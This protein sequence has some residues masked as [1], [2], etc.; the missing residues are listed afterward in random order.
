VKIHGDTSSG[1]CLK[2]KYTADHLGLP[3]TWIA[4]SA[5]DG[6]TKRPEFLARNP[7]GQIPVIE[8]DDGRHL[9]QSNAIIRY[10]ARGT[11]LLPDDPFTQ[12]KIDEW[13][14]WEQYS[15]EPYIAV[16]RFHMLYLGRPREAREAWRVERGEAALDLMERHLS[17]H[18][19][20]VGATIT[21][22]DIALLAYTR[23]AADGGFDLSP[24]PNVNGWIAR[25]ERA[26]GLSDKGCGS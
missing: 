16:C 11:E 23:V 19:Y 20:L 15:H 26:L 5:L 21:I 14:F 12:A 17:S 24:R 8:L 7:F 25:C 3:Y 13:L 22:A 10:L 18:P 9:A 1:N 4:V 2:I 6:E